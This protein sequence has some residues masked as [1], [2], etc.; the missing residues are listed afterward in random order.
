MSDSESEYWARKLGLSGADGEKAKR[1]LF[2]EFEELDGL[3]DEFID[4]FKFMDE[5]PKPK[6]KKKSKVLSIV[7]ESAVPVEEMAPVSTP[8]SGKYIP[9]HARLRNSHE[10][11]VVLSSESKESVSLV[12]LLNRVS[13][14]NLDS[15]SAE[16]ISLITRTKS[17]TKYVADCIVSMAC[18]NPHITVTLQG[19]FAG[20]VCAIAADTAPSTRYSGAVLVCLVN[21]M[22]SQESPRTML[23]YVR[24]T[25]MLF[26]LGLLSFDVVRNMALFC[27]VYPDLEIRL[28]WILTILRFSG[29]VM[30]D[31]Y[32]QR[33]APLLEELANACTE[34]VLSKKS[35][36]QIK[37]LRLMSQSNFRAVDHL[38]TV[39]EW[40]SVRSAT[41]KSKNSTA[42]S[43]STLSGWKVPSSVEAVQLLQAGNV[44]NEG[45]KWPTEWTDEGSVASTIPAPA[46]TTSLEE[47]A[48]LNRMNTDTKK[49][50]FI[51]IM[52][53]VDAGHAVLRLDQFGLVENAKNIPAIVH[54]VC[55]CAL[56]EKKINPFYG[57]ILA[58]LCGVGG[59]LNLTAPL[60]RKMKISFKIELRKL[61]ASGTLDEAEIS[62]V[63]QLVSKL[64]S[65]SDFTIEEIF[66]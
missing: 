29:R 25:A 65:V 4:L 58:A 26:S 20:I 41:G 1:K 21:R 27:N 40:L 46:A 48:R 7:E 47:L 49:N 13:E 66:A 28:D 3:D 35:E 33:F 38:Q 23:N 42:N 52:G 12:G 11:N 30:K 39:C 22:R 36:F 56:Q 64:V 57:E 43:G 5:I 24:F 54:V 16:I 55:H 18:D 34:T 31:N 44:F 62:V 37:E 51:A 45:Y 32:K 60:Q 9:P 19:T 53:A 50:S 2:R 8:T 6:K 63:S 59:K 17:S 15:I 10:G 14:G 61:I